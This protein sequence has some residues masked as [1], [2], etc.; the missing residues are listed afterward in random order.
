MIKKDIEELTDD[1]LLELYKTVD[2]FIS[3]LKKE[4]EGAENDW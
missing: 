1:E 3:Y 2:D 4:L